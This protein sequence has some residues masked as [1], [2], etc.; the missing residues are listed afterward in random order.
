MKLRKT[1]FLPWMLLVGVLLFTASQALSQDI[2][3]V[4]FSNGNCAFLAAYNAPPDADP[5]DISLVEAG[6]ASAVRL[7]LTRGATPYVV[8]DAGSLL[9]ERIADLY[10]MQVTIAVENPD[11]EFHA[12]SGE[13]TAFDGLNATQVS[14]SWSVY[15]ESK[16]PNIAR[17]TVEDSTA[18]FSGGG[19]LFVINKKIDNAL[20]ENHRPSNLVIQRIAFFDRLGAALPVN[21]DAVF[22]PPEGFGQV[23][24]AGLVSVG[25]ETLLEG[26]QGTS[27]GFGQAC[28]FMTLKND[29][30]VL[31]AALL[32]PGCVVTVYYASATP[33]ELIL[34]SWTQGA[35]EGAGWAKVAPSAV[36]ASATIAQYLHADLASAFGTD[37]FAEYLDQLYVGD[38]GESLAVSA[39]TIALGQ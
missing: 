36:N 5:L 23:D 22:A 6:G 8:I 38:T 39:V 24:R 35:P 18:T 33:P 30:G 37:A 9:G 20:D 27:A 16:N 1:L 12:V 21:P 2:T 31:D 14:G 3:A 7:T 28:A 17:I 10:E 34:Q 19:A 25:G 15:L 26:A 13:L 11:G 4:D 29:G 32:V